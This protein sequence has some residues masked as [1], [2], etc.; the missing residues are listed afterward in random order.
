MA[1]ELK[2]DETIA[3]L[4]RRLRDKHGLTLHE[5][6]ELSGVHW[7]TIAKLE[8]EDRDPNFTTVLSLLAAL[9]YVVK[10]TKRR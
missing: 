10:I 4:L 8:R 7:N 2:P 5:L 9:G 6:S 3:K 1:N